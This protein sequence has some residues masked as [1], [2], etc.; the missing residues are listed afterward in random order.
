MSGEFLP[1]PEELQ[2]IAD[3]ERMARMAVEDRI[4]SERMARFAA[5]ARADAEEAARLEAEERL[6]AME[7]ELRRLRSE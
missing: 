4:D 6:A 5:Q 1:T 3:S 2:A 7:A